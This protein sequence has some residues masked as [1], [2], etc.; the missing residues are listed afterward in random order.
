[1]LIYLEFFK[2]KH[3][4]AI[5]IHSRLLKTFPNQH[6]EC[7]TNLVCQ[8]YYITP[9]PCLNLSAC[10][11]NELLLF[12]CISVVANFGHLIFSFIRVHGLFLRIACKMGVIYRICFYSLLLVISSWQ[13]NAVELDYVELNDEY[14]TTDESTLVEYTTIVDDVTS[15]T[16]D[17]INETIAIE[18]DLEQL[19]KILKSFT[20]GIRQNHKKIDIVF[21]VDS[22]S[23]VGKANFRNEIKFVVKFL[24]DFN[25]SYNYTRVAIITFSSN[26][27]IVGVI[28]LIERDII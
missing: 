14:I 19:S 1:M 22:S 28:S 5:A 23:S 6:Q 12:S 21:L 11:Q 9:N 10:V 27:K 26:D 18:S 20:H 24:S 25:V 15:T 2:L 17:S 8:R 13:D 4:I 7:C 16:I 3:S